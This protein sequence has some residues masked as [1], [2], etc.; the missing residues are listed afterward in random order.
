MGAI[1]MAQNILQIVL[2]VVL[3][4]AVGILAVLI[5]IAS[6]VYDIHRYV[7]T[8]VQRVAHRRIP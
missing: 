2:A 6:W 8:I 3:A 4:C 5:W 7:R 1:D